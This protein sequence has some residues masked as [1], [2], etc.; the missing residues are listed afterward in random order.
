MRIKCEEC[1]NWAHGWQQSDSGKEAGETG[2]GFPPHTLSQRSTETDDP[3][4]WP[5]TSSPL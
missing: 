2:P 3:L 4:P 1:P 5:H